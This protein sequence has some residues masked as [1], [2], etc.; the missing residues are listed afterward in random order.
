M[1]FAIRILYRYDS[2][3][4]IF[5]VPPGGDGFYY[6]AT[7]LLVQADEWARF[8]I[9]IN[10]EVLCT[11]DTSQYD[12]PSDAGQAACSG[13]IYATEGRQFVLFV[14]LPVMSNRR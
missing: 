14:T 5:T 4:G 7:Y 6:F 11:A 2:T 12:T 9:R 8:E 1:T 13:A 10:G 3:T